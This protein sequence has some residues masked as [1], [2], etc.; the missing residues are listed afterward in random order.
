MSTAVRQLRIILV[1][2][3]TSLGGVCGLPLLRGGNSYPNTEVTLTLKYSDTLLTNYLMHPFI[4]NKQ[5]FH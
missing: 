1:C 2:S 4:I 3:W 5:N